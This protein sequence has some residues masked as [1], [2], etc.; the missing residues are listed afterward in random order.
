MKKVFCIFWIVLLAK[1]ASATSALWFCVLN[2]QEIQEDGITK[3]TVADW[4]EDNESHGN[5]VAFRIRVTGDGVAED[6]FLPLYYTLEGSDVTYTATELSLSSG[7]LPLLFQQASVDGYSASPSLYS[8]SLELGTINY[9]VNSDGEFVTYARTDENTFDA[10]TS[11][12]SL[13]GTTPPPG[14]QWN[15]LIYGVV[16]EPMTTGLLLAGC[17]LLALRRR[18]FV[19]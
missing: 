18:T 13:G 6:T 5:E 2:D 17:A 7:T 4:V 8:V 16:P 19:A 9:D 1:F 15:P 14:G 11:F 3:W 12:I 10:L